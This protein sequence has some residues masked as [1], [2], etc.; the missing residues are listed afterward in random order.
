MQIEKM[1]AAPGRMSRDIATTLGVSG[2]V[3]AGLL[4][5]F[6]AAAASAQNPAQAPHTKSGPTQSVAGNQP[7]AAVAAPANSTSATSLM[8]RSVSIRNSPG[9]PDLG[10]H[11]I[12]CGLVTGNLK[13]VEPN[14]VICVT[15]TGTREGH[16]QC[17]SI[18]P[19]G[20]DCKKNRS[21]GVLRSPCGVDPSLIGVRTRFSL[22]FAGSRCAPERGRRG[23]HPFVGGTRCTNV[24]SRCASNHSFLRGARFSNCAH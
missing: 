23:E 10:G 2:G 1:R 6:I 19:P 11:C 7:V 5:L 13:A 17:T 18:C 9:V 15:P 14:L 3:G 24:G 21:V 8:M 16:R 22:R 4:G 12:I 20:H